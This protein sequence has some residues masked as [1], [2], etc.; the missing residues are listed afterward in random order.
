MDTDK[1]TCVTCIFWAKYDADKG[2]CRRY[3]PSYADKI[4][5]AVFPTTYE[6]TWCGEH[7]KQGQGRG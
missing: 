2:S 1:P 7:T 6:T 3:P 4:V 5:G